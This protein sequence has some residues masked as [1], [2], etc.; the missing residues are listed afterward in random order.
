MILKYLVL[1]EED[2]RPRIKTIFNIKFLSIMG[3]FEVILKIPKVIKL[4]NLTKSKIIE[5]NPDI[6]ITIDAPGFNFRLQKS[7]KSLVLNKFTMLP[8]LYGHGKVIELKKLLN[9]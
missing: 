8:H 6:V 9:F 2:D 3:I 1:V 7:I 4:L 5:I